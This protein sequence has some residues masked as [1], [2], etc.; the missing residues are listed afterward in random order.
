MT[1]VTFCRAD[2]AHSFCLMKT[3]SR[4][5]GTASFCH[6]KLQTAEG[7]RRRQGEKQLAQGSLGSYNNL[8]EIKWQV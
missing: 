6:Y 5:G 1:T 8:G 2:E 4:A 7:G 3:F